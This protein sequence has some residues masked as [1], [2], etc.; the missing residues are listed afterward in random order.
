MKMNV[1]YGHQIIIKFMEMHGIFHLICIKVNLNM[2]FIVD[3]VLMGCQ[4]VQ[5]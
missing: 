3:D 5:F 1:T 2:I 4:F